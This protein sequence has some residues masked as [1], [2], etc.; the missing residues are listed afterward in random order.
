MIEEEEIQL[1]HILLMNLYCYRFVK[2]FHK[3]FSCSFK[4]TPLIVT[5]ESNRVRMVDTQTVVCALR[6]KRYVVRLC[7]CLSTVP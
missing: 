2:K 7:I 3:F 4:T 6:E 5:T 1:V